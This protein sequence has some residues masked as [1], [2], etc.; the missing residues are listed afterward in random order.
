MKIFSFA[1]LA[2]REFYPGR[3]LPA[4]QFLVVLLS[5]TLAG[6]TH[7]LVSAVRLPLQHRPL[8]RQSV[9][10][11]GMDNHFESGS[12][13]EDEK[14]QSGSFVSSGLVREAALFP[15]AVD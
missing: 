11:V 8:L 9:V 7:G 1:K 14:P 6:V 12:D 15:A 2:A 3:T 4:G 13:V 5:S 10:A